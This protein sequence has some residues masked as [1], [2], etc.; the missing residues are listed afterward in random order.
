M[1]EHREYANQT[2]RIC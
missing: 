1:T 2:P